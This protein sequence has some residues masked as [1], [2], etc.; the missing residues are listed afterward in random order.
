MTED[1]NVVRS[2]RARNLLLQRC[3][4]QCTKCHKF[5]LARRRSCSLCRSTNLVQQPL[6][7]KGVIIALCFS[8][9][10]IETLDQMSHLLLVGLV[11][12]NDNSFINCRIAYSRPNRK[13]LAALVNKPCRIAVRRLN[14]KLAPTAP[15]T[16]GMKAVLDIDTLKQL[17]DGDN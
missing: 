12:L 13:K 16:Y 1:L 5:S 9:E 7:R 4:W 3:G 17:N 8:G 10:T 14:N 11:Q 15:I 6:P 2:W